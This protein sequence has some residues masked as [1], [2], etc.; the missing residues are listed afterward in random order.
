MVM[1]L[2]TWTVDQV[3]CKLSGNSRST[4]LSRATFLQGQMGC[5]TVLRLG[6]IYFPFKIWSH[7]TYHILN[8]T[9]HISFNFNITIS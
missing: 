9:C 4:G 2:V 7:I 3:V 1:L 8:V 5:V 6:H